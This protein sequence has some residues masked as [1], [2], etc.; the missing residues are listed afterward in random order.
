MHDFFEISPLAQYT[1]YNYLAKYTYMYIQTHIRGVCVYLD[2]QLCD[3]V[4][5]KLRVIIVH[6]K[7]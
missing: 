7:N 5:L 4:I 2:I 3:S 1:K 6:T